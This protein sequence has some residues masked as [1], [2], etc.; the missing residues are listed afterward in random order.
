MSY[1]CFTIII[2]IIIIIIIFIFLTLSPVVGNIVVDIV[3]AYPY[4]DIHLYSSAT[5][6]LSLY[7]FS[8]LHFFFPLLFFF[9]KFLLLFFLFIIFLFLPISISHFLLSEPLSGTQSFTESSS[10]ADQTM[11]KF[12]ASDHRFELQERILSQAKYPT[13]ITVKF[14]PRKNIR[15]SSRFRFVCEY[16][17]SFDFV[18]QGEGTYEEHE[19]KPISPFPK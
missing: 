7:F 1:Y 18:L 4:R 8:S 17:N 16:G 3:S 14:S 15:Y 12:N 19:H 6:S 5:L 10:A 2:T 9:K 11:S 13:P